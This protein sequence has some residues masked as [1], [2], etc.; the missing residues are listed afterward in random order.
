MRGGLQLVPA[1]ALDNRLADLM[2][3]F[4]LRAKMIVHPELDE[5]DLLF[6]LFRHSQLHFGN[7]RYALV[8]ARDAAVATL[9]NE[10]L[11]GGEDSCFRGPARALLVAEF[12]DQVLIGAHADDAR[13]AVRS[14]G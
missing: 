5:I 1:R 10:T 7:A 2:R 3:H 13:D 14:V 8:H 6:C 4:L 12:E 11:T 9:H